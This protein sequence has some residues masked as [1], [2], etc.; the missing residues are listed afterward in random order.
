MAKF[1]R[2]YSLIAMKKMREPKIN[3]IYFFSINK[4]H[5]NISR[6]YFGI[7]NGESNDIILSSHQHTWYI[8]TLYAIE[9]NRK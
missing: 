3:S 9:S 1:N 6:L 8:L 4:N 2:I 5:P 7:T